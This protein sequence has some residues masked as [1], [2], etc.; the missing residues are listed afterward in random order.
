MKNGVMFVAGLVMAIGL[1][2]P[3]TSEA[4]AVN[5]GIMMPRPAPMPVPVPVP[6]PVRVPVPVFGSHGFPGGFPMFPPPIRPWCG[7]GFMPFY[8]GFGGGYCYPWR[9]PRRRHFSLAISFG[10]FNFAINTGRWY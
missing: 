8:G 6:F 2:F 3:N 4:Y 1:M 10:R 5:V 9:R 7:P